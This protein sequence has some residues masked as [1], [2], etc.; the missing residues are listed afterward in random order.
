MVRSIKVFGM[1]ILVAVFFSLSAWLSFAQSIPLYINYMGKLVD[2]TSGSLIW[3]KKSIIFS[4]YEDE[5]GGDPIYQ[6]TRQVNITNGTFSIY[7]GKGE[8]YYQGS[9]VDDGIPAEVFTH[10]AAKYLG[11][12]IADSAAEMSPRKLIGS[13]AYAY[14]AKEAERSTELIGSQ[15]ERLVPSGTIVMWSGALASIPVGWALC[16]G[17]NGTPDL[18]DKFIYGA[19]AGEE[20]GTTGGAHHYALTTDQLPSHTHIATCS[21]NGTHMHMTRYNTFHHDGGE[22]GHLYM[23][24][25]LK[26]AEYPHYE[27]WRD[28]SGYAGGHAHSITLDNTG[29]GKPIDNRPAYYRLALIMKL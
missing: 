8:G 16:D 26:G 29:A 19:T 17:T 14:K 5:T 9:A 1:S 3:G 6:Q 12:K 13:V 22:P 10:H 11:I 24:A 2:Q 21:T 20:P 18:R 27:V 25:P 7:L 28:L 4:L 15:V 23:D